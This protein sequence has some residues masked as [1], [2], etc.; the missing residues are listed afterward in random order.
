MSYEAEHLVM[1]VLDGIAVAIQ[2]INGITFKLKEHCSEREIEEGLCIEDIR[3][4]Q[5]EFAR[6]SNW[7]WN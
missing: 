3:E 5:A 4:I 1:L 6:Q 2:E 7:K